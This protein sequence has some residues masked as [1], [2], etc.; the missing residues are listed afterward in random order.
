MDMQKA[1][2]IVITTSSLASAFMLFSTSVAGY[3]YGDT[4]AAFFSPMLKWGCFM[5]IPIAIL[6]SAAMWSWSVSIGW[7]LF[8]VIFHIFLACVAVF[9]WFF[10]F[11]HFP[12]PA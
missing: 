1:R 12:I 2:T 7:K 3:F 8:I 9:V 11:F 6:V 10:C 4:G 5:V